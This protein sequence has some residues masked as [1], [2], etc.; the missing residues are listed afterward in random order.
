MIG[1]IR[2]IPIDLL[3]DESLAELE[4]GHHLLLVQGGKT[5]AEIIPNPASSETSAEPT[6][7]KRQAA[8]DAFRAMLR[9]GFDLDGL[10]VDREELYSDR[11]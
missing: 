10:K 7:E 6:S 1:Q 11:G 9:Q 4:R 8:V 5:I 3:D 2:K